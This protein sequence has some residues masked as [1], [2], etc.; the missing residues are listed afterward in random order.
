METPLDPPPH[1]RAKLGRLFL[2]FRLRK[3]GSRACDGVGGSEVTPTDSAQAGGRKLDGGSSSATGLVRLVRP[4][5]EMGGGA[6]AT[7]AE[8]EACGAA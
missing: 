3:S 2:P 8:G 7:E 6:A 4:T 5:A 1:L